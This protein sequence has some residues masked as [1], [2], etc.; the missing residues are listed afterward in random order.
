MKSTSAWVLMV[1]LG[2]PSYYF[3]VVEYV[4]YWETHNHY[5]LVVVEIVVPFLRGE[6]HRIQHL[7]DLGVSDFGWSE[8]FTDEVY[9]MLNRVCMSFFLLLDY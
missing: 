8:D 4:A 9:M 1:V 3:S 2:G 6:E 5:D 7:L